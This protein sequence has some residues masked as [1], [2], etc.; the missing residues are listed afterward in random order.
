MEEQGLRSAACPVT[1]AFIFAAL[2]KRLVK[3]STNTLHL[4]E[5]R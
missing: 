5:E 3:E 4:L 2:W 1:R